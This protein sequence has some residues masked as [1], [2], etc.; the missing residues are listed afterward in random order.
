MA[1]ITDYDFAL[2]TLNGFKS[3]SFIFCSNWITYESQSVVYT[4]K[5]VYLFPNKFVC[6]VRYKLTYSEYDWH[7]ISVKTSCPKV[8]FLLKFLYFIFGYVRIVNSL[9]YRQFLAQ[10][11]DWLYSLRVIMKLLFSQLSQIYGFTNHISY[12]YRQLSCPMV[13][14]GYIA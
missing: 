3:N 9:I 13:L 1:Q 7:E 8:L 12:I 6:W 14:I 2:D 11:C 4:H 10:M 5:Q